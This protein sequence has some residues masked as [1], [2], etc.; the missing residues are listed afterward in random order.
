MSGFPNKVNFKI[1]EDKTGKLK[2]AHHNH[3][4]PLKVPTHEQPKLD[5]NISEESSSS[6]SEGESE[7]RENE[8]ETPR[9]PRRQRKQRERAYSR[10]EDS[11]G[12]F[13]NLPLR[14]VVALP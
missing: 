12:F 5:S 7:V 9:Y 11:Y 13:A 6:Q 2:V 4:T 10:H 1:K 8:S 14:L 3:L